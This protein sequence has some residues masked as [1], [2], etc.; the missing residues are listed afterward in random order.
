MVA[1]LEW[2]ITTVLL[3]TTALVY[4]IAGV[5]DL[6]QHLHHLSALLYVKV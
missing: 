1:T 5:K 4:V 6:S 3:I 2:E